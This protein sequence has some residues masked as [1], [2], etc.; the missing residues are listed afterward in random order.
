MTD[1]ESTHCVE[2]TTFGLIN[3][4]QWGDLAYVECAIDGFGMSPNTCDSDG[5]SLLHWAAINNRVEIIQYLVKKSVDV[6]ISGGDNLEI[7]L[8]WAFRSRN[9][10]AQIQIL[11]AE[12]ADIRHKSSYGCD[13]LF[14]AVQCNK[15]SAAFLILNAGA[16][17]NTTDH[18]GDTPL[19]WL[20]RKHCGA[21]NREYLD[22]LRLLVRFKSSVTVTSRDG[23]NALH[24]LAGYS[25]PNLD[26]ASAHLLY[27]SGEDSM[28][29]EKN[30]KG[31][32]PYDVRNMMIVCSIGMIVC[33]IGMIVLDCILIYQVA[34]AAKNSEMVRFLYDAYLFKTLPFCFPMISA[35]ASFCSLFICLHILGWL[36][37]ISAYVLIF[38]L[39][40]SMSQSYIVRG[41]SRAPCGMAWAIIIS[42]ICC[43]YVL[44]SRYFTV[45][46]DIVGALFSVVIFYTLSKTS[47]TSP[48][49]LY[50]DSSDSRYQLSP[51]SSHSRITNFRNKFF[52][53]TDW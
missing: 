11:L 26:M 23:C 29:T 14:V 24:I 42:A 27:E 35:A 5:C 17:P 9:C 51:L 40:E 38:L 16:D 30:A 1:E 15:L 18:N 2:Y 22:M 21:P 47:A 50:G 12:E 20:L 45:F 10:L 6:N 41:E 44:F 3:A 48:Q 43:Y 4:V 28:L 34:V 8:Q 33:S 7:P 46:V 32:T 39:S 53:E 19:Y 49:S 37:G 13:S 31:E 36:Y 52:A 25:G